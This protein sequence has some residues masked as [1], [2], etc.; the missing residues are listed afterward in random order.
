MRAED[1][2]RAVRHFAE[3]LDEARALGDQALDDMAVVHDLVAHIDRR[4]VFLQRQLDDVDRAHD[5]RTES[6]RL[7]QNDLQ[8]VL[9]RVLQHSCPHRLPASLVRRPMPCC[10][11]KVESGKRHA[12]KKLRR[13]AV[14]LHRAGAV[15][16]PL[17]SMLSR[18]ALKVS[19]RNRAL[20]LRASLSRRG[21]S[22][23]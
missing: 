12:A 10:A 16:A 2:D 18:T 6:A 19:C 11:A 17:R 20:Q 7:G 22:G 21:A 13:V 4:A 1:G 3:L 15:F 9:H 5:A 23:G 8:A 14:I